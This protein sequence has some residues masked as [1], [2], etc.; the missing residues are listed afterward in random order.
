M[1]QVWS[2]M[3]SAPDPICMPADCALFYGQCS[4]CTHLDYFKDSGRIRTEVYRKPTHTD[5]YIHY[6]SYH[7]QHIKTGIIRTLI[8]RSEQICNTTE[9]A[10]HERRHLIQVFQSNG[11]L[12]A[13]IQRA[14]NPKRTLTKDKQAAPLATTSIPYIKGTSERIRRCLSQVDIRVA[15]RSRSTM[16]SLLMRVRLR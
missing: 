12:T 9:A 13:F 6:Q 10:D 14:M 1:D 3:V 2:W 11:Y 5:R 4:G 8:R 16:R 15:F 7:P